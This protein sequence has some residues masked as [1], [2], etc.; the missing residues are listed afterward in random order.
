MFSLHRITGTIVS[1]FFFMW[2]VSGL[3][4]IY[5]PYPKA[6]Q[7]QKNERMDALPASLPD[8]QAI[9]SRISDLDKNIKSLD[10]RSFQNQTLFSVKTKDSLYVICAD[11]NEQVKPITTHTFN[12][13]LKKWV[14][15]PIVKVDTLIEREQ[16]VLYSWYE[17]ELP[18]YRYYFDDKEK[19]QLYLSSR[20]GE[21]L[22]FTDKDQ[23][24]WAWLGSIPHKFYIPSLRRNTNTWTNSLTIGGVIALIAALSGMYLGIYAVYR[25]YKVKQ[26]IGSPYKKHWYK[27]HHILGLIF[28]IFLATFAFSGAM[29]LQR[30]PQWAIKTHGD[31][32]VS[33]SQLRGKRLSI[34]QYKLDYRSLVKEYPDIKMIQ[35]SHFQNLPIYNVVVGDTEIC[36][37]A[38]SSEIKELNLSQSQIEKAVQDVH[39]ENTLKSVTL[40]NE[41]EEYYLSRKRGLVLPVYKIEVDNADN[42]LYYIDPKTGD[43]KYLNKS[44]KAK[45]W[46]FSALHYLNIKYLVERPVLWSI[47]IWILCLGGAYVSFSGVWLGVKYIRRKV[48]SINYKI[49]KIRS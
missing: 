41:Y 26:K 7:E 1:L 8:I 20:T 3:V 31:Y 34:D 9:L 45:K 29:A 44:R 23:R 19:H 42:S 11:S 27:W 46:I 35:W 30:I 21:V 48:K 36:I 43:F 40:I 24:F 6:T 37:D 12:N 25:K 39:T 10:I 16:W 22:Q 47:A 38:S 32:R 28:G 18:I 33:S 13:I 14:N 2:F 5:H 49:R 17:K 15:A 4:L